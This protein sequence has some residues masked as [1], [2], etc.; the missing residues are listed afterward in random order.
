[1][2]LKRNDG[3]SDPQFSSVISKVFNAWD[4]IDTP[5]VKIDT[6]F[7]ISADLADID[8]SRAQE[9]SRNSESLKEEVGAAE[10][11]ESSYAEY[12]STRLAIRAYFALLLTGKDVESDF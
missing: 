4:A 12:Y 7:K 9:Y 2:F 1:M 10:S 8:F 11:E 5:W 3:F 6:G